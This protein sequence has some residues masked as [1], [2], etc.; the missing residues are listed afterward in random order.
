MGLMDSA[1]WFALILLADISAMVVWDLYE[2]KRKQRLTNIKCDGCTKPRRTRRTPDKKYYLC[3]ECM[4]IYK[5]ENTLP[6]KGD[7][8]I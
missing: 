7:C 2:R 8:T 3:R 1:I 6:S 4:K 5:I